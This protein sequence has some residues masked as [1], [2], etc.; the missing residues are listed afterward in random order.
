[1]SERFDP[2]ARMVL[3][4]A[5]IWGPA[6]YV[7]LR[8]A[9]DT[10]ATY[11]MLSWQAAV[12]LGYDPATAPDRVQL[13]TASAVEYAPQFRISKLRALGQERRRFPILCHTL[14]SSARVDGLLGLD[15]FRDRRL[16]LD[17][18]EGTVSLD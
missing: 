6:G 9:V 2:H 15:F 16:V 12:I 5:E 7:A 11:S 4:T 13:V 17:F 3:A 8:L 18:R 1:M 10:G 14:P